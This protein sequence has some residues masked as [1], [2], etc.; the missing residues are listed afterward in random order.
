MDALVY[1]SSEHEDDEAMEQHGGDADQAFDNGPTD[2]VAAG[3][4]AMD[5]AVS[6]PVGT[7]PGLNA[8]EEGQAA[9]GAAEDKQ[10]AAA[11]AAEQPATGE[12]AEATAGGMQA[13]EERADGAPADPEAASNQA[14]D[15]PDVA[16]AEAQQP[17]GEA[18]SGGSGKSKKVRCAWCVDPRGC[19]R[20]DGTVISM[21]KGLNHVLTCY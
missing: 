9:E 14:D 18:P 20:R 11:Y 4:L 21:H 2:A 17:G 8:Q 12:A 1:Y 6:E 10:E 16:A 3:E 15:K 19:F 13:E 5:A 7:A